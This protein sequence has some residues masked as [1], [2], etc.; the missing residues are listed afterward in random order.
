MG[1]TPRGLWPAMFPL[2]T[3]PANGQ[4][5]W[6]SC[7][8][9]KFELSPIG[10]TRWQNSYTQFSAQSFGAARSSARRTSGIDSKCP[11]T[12]GPQLY[13]LPAGA[14][15][16]PL[17]PLPFVPF[18]ALLAFFVFIFDFAISSSPLTILS[19]ANLTVPLGRSR[20]GDSPFAERPERFTLQGQKLSLSN[21]GIAKNQRKPHQSICELATSCQS[22]IVDARQGLAGNRIGGGGPA[23]N[24]TCKRSVGTSTGPRSLL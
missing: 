2:C 22:N 3:Y 8:L 7:G 6:F 18:P 24:S 15:L 14:F 10:R 4:A 23:Q 20:T 12:C 19:P 16:A 17:I 21:G 1:L 5:L 13:P 9:V 11:E